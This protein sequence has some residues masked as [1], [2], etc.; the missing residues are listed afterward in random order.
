L[1][2]EMINDLKIPAD[3]RDVPY[4]SLMK[5]MLAEKIHEMKKRKAA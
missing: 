2:E 1:P 5:I 3:Q 4:Q